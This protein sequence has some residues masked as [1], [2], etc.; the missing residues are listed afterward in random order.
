MVENMDVVHD[1][2]ILKWKVRGDGHGVLRQ[3]ICKVLESDIE[4]GDRNRQAAIHIEFRTELE[5][6]LDNQCIENT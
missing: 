5:Y 3:N 1:E 2:I 4:L 6:F